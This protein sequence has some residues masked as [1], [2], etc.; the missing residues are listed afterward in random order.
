MKVSLLQRKSSVKG[1]ALVISLVMLAIVTVMAIIFLALS[2]R[3]RQS[4]LMTEDMAVA[5]EMAGAALERAKAQAIA[6][7]E[8]TGSKLHYDLFNST[9]FINPNGFDLSLGSN[10]AN[11]SYLR[12]NSTNFVNRDEFLRVVANL[13]F[14]PRPPVFVPTNDNGA[15]E[16]R[17]YLDFNRDREFETNGF[18]MQVDTNGLP[19]MVN[20]E[21]LFGRLVGD[22]EWIGVLEKPEF[23]HSETNRFVGRMAY[24]ALPVGKTLDINFIHNQADPRA[25]SPNI[26]GP[27][28]PNGFARNQGYGSWEINL[29]G[30]LAGLNTNNYAWGPLSY[31]WNSVNALPFGEAFDNARSLLAFRYNDSKITLPTATES[32]GLNEFDKDNID[33]YGDGPYVINWTKSGKGLNMDKPADR[34]QDP[35]PGGVNTN[36]FTDIQ[37]LFSMGAY[38]ADFTNRLQAPPKQTRSSYDK[39][40]FYRLLSQLGADSTPALKGKMHLNYV[41]PVGEVTNNF[42]PWVAATNGAVQFFTQAADLM[43]KASINGTV[44]NNFGTFYNLAGTIVPTNFSV[45]NI[46]LFSKVVSSNTFSTGIFGNEYTPAIHR[47]LQIAANVYDSTFNRTNRSGQLV[48]PH[49]PT[50]FRP[51]FTFTTTNAYISGFVEVT[52]NASI[53]AAQPWMDGREMLSNNVT[54]VFT[55]INLWGGHFIVGAKKG[56]P[57]F[58]ELTMQAYVEL[59]RKIELAKPAAGQPVNQTNQLFVVSMMNRWGLEAW[60]SYLTNYNRNIDIRG[61][62][63]STVVIRDDSLNVPFGS[64]VY[65]N[66]LPL[67]TIQGIT[68][69]VNWAPASTRQSYVTLINTNLVLLADQDYFNG[70]FLPRGQGTFH[71]IQAAPRLQMYTTND[72]RFWMIDRTEDRFID[73]VTFD[74]LATTMSMTNLQSTPTVLT[75]PNTGFNE[76]VLWDP[77]PIGGA[78]SATVGITNQL[79]ISTGDIPVDDNTWR[80]FKLSGDKDRGIALWRRFVGLSLRQGD[81]I[82]PAPTELRYQTPFVP[83]RRMFEQY[84]WQVNDPLVHYMAQDLRGDDESWYLK[85]LK[86][87]DPLPSWNIGFLNAAYSPWGG[88]P[89]KQPKHKSM[90]FNYVLQDPGIRKSD[91]WQFP[92]GDDDGSYRFPSI[93]ALGQVHR[94]TPW[95]TINLKAIY[96]L[97]QNGVFIPKLDPKVWRDYWAGTVSTYPDQD[98]RLLDV[99]TVAPNENAA[100]GLLSVN[101]ANTAAWSAVLAGVI[102]PKTKVKNAELRGLG[103]HEFIPPDEGFDAIL[104]QPGSPEINKIVSTIN[105]VRANQK[106]LV[107]NLNPATAN[108]IPFVPQTR[109]NFFAVPPQPMSVFHTVGEVLAAPGLTV[110][111]PYINNHPLQVQ[112]VWTDQAVEYI[113]QQILSLLKT[114]E[115]RFVVYAFGQSLK[116]APHSL[117]TSAEYYNLCTNYQITGEVITKT[118]FRVEGELRSSSNPLRAVVESYNVLPPPE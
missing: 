75:S 106:E 101:Q 104:I 14:D 24:L 43:L 108:A 96:E 83:T 77:R 88:N 80:A 74:N 52:N 109:T 71:P 65:S 39:Y 69:V 49:F 4:V 116:P 64:V 44:T 5:S 48:Y 59:S 55:N 20:N 3:E 31:N 76:D 118:T 33:N 103:Q 9:N 66:Q 23:P 10:P 97:D 81:P 22:P 17:Y 1:I 99:F 45:T 47:I 105:F 107:N 42:V 50:V 85:I 12:K 8:A 29:A 36:A 110:Q 40:T 98:Y 6:H 91:D 73:F 82:V 13:Q 34:P 112:H 100:S 114:D 78:N 26:S 19:I 117:V 2:R 32:L 95:Q 87:D 102:A 79:A 90:L 84:T 57:A 35:W 46:Q 51:N 115:P 67:G 41:N 16:F 62:V 68:N 92:I 7:M 37:Q 94:G 58:N 38:S 25:S 11:V 89:N 28:A 27:R 54:G 18:L 86:I 15:L 21:P 111:S 61:S 63:R 56:H 53:I 93:G 70:L 113:P 30:F 72:V 60:N